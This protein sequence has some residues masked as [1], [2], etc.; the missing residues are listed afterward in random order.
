MKVTNPQFFLKWR[1]LFIIQFILET[2]VK[3]IN[4]S[5]Y[6]CP[7]FLFSVRGQISHLP[8]H[9]HWDEVLLKQEHQHAEWS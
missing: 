7:S 1:G 4:N 2:K 8:A 5:L 6:H 3:Q 9:L